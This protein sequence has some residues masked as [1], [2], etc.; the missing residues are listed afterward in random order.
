M[1]LVN[2]VWFTLLIVFALIGLVGVTGLL[3]VVRGRNA[4]KWLITYLAMFILFICLHSAF[5]TYSAYESDNVESFLNST[6]VN[7][8]KSVQKGNAPNGTC[9]M[10][11]AMSR[12]LS[13]CDV[14]GSACCYG[15]TSGMCFEKLMESVKGSRTFLV[16][17]SWLMF[18]VEF[19]IILLVTFMLGSV[20]YETRHRKRMSVYVE[21]TGFNPYT[22]SRLDTVLEDV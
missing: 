5:F 3:G 18:S 12:V 16:L 21:N 15:G 1:S 17:A 7:L 9:L 20:N 6:I 11:K 22:L 2:D 14:T 4:K 13:C 10:M 19:V 8:G